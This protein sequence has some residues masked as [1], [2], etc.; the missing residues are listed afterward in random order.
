MIDSVVWAQYINVTDRQTDSH[1]AIAIV[2][3]V[4]RIERLNVKAELPNTAVDVQAKLGLPHARHF[5][6]NTRK[7]NKL[8]KIAVKMLDCQHTAQLSCCSTTCNIVLMQRIF[9]STAACSYA[10]HAA[11]AT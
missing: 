9:F 11:A 2:A 5:L 4:H 3:L 10:Q 8:K 7:S 6:L 1:V